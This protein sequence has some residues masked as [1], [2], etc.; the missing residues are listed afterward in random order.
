MYTYSRSGLCHLKSC[1]GGGWI[2]E[3]PHIYFFF[4]PH[5]F[6]REPSW[7]LIFL[8]KPRTYSY[9]TPLRILN[10]IVLMCYLYSLHTSH[11]LRLAREG[12]V[13]GH[14]LSY[15]HCILFT[16]LWDYSGRACCWGIRLLLTGKVKSPSNMP[17]SSSAVGSLMDSLSRPK[18]PATSPPPALPWDLSWTHYRLIEVNDEVDETSEGVIESVMLIWNALVI[19]VCVKSWTRW[20]NHE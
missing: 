6:F 10:G 18:A 19:F 8:P 7:Y 1:R 20:M 13:L 17:S 14:L 15:T 11:Y 2:I 16:T 12:I 3:P 5:I 9:S 4:D